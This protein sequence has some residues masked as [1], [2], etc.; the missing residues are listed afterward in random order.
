MPE[1]RPDDTELVLWYE[2]DDLDEAEVLV[3][4]LARDKIRGIIRPVPLSEYTIHYQVW[5]RRL[6]RAG[7]QTC[8][9]K[10]EKSQREYSR[11]VEPTF[12]KPDIPFGHPAHRV[13]TIGSIVVAAGV[14]LLSFSV[15]TGACLILAGL[16]VAAFR[17][18]LARFQQYQLI[19]LFAL[20][21]FLPPSIG[22]TIAHTAPPWTARPIII[23]AGL[24][25]ACALVWMGMIGVMNRVYYLSLFARLVVWLPLSLVLGIAWFLI[26]NIAAHP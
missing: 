18:G 6:D 8:L 12:G 2:T 5:L 19:D 10:L 4:H 1:A 11:S 16:V 15:E 21:A 3:H 7:A 17:R 26:W 24:I 23:L 9:E 22:L 14:V 25:L 13:T 20:C